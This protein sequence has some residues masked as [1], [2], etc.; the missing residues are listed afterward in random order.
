MVTAFTLGHSV[1]LVWCVVKGPLLPIVWVEALIPLTIIANCVANFFGTKQTGSWWVRYVITALFGL[2]HGMGFSNFLKEMLEPQ[3]APWR[4]LLAFNL[5]V[6]IG[7]IVVVLVCL[8]LGSWVIKISQITIV[9][10][11][12]AVSL[13]CAGAATV[14][15]LDRL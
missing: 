10:W 2:V 15:L 6:E 12:L 1:T 3:A 14:L 7:Q 9:R 4:Q 5:G 13:Y 11:S 8:A